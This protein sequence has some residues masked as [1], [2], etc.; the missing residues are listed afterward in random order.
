MARSGTA[1]AAFCA[2]RQ[3]RPTVEPCQPPNLHRYGRGRSTPKATRARHPG[4]HYGL[5]DVAVSGTRL[6]FSGEPIFI[7]GVNWHMDDPRGGR[8]LLAWSTFR[9]ILI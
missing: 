8:C 5:V 3:P 2:R 7:K 1:T 4:E 6:T 9:G